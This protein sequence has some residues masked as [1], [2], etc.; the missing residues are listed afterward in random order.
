MIIIIIKLKIDTLLLWH[1]GGINP[2]THPEEQAPVYLLHALSRQFDEH[3]WVQLLPYVPNAQSDSEKNV[4]KC[5]TLDYGQCICVVFIPSL[6]SGP[7]KPGGHVH[8]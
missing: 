8:P 6:Q 5:F 4:K 7:V 3:V 1:F 2:R